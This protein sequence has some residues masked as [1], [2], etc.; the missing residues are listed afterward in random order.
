MHQQLIAESSSLSFQRED[1]HYREIHLK[2]HTLLWYYTRNGYLSAGLSLP[3][4]VISFIGWSDAN[5][6]CIK[7]AAHQNRPKRENEC[8]LLDCPAGNGK[9]FWG[10]I[11]QIW[12]YKI[13][14]WCLYGFCLGGLKRQIKELF[15]DKC[16]SLRFRRKRLRSRASTKFC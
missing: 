8:P 4:T 14:F 12:T 1:T 13:D 16:C 10:K 15:P 7:C 3:H 2:Q 6:F 11:S 9:A 5:P